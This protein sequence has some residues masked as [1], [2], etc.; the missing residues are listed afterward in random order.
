MSGRAS[1]FPI[2][3]SIT[4]DELESDLH[5]AFARLRDS[6]PVSWVGALDAWLVTSRDAA[7]TMMR[8][9]D[10]FTV[11]DPRFSTAQV[12]G[13]SMLSLDGAEHARHRDPFADAFRLP[14]VR[15][16]FTHAV[17]SLADE[18]IETMR[19]DGRGELRRQLAGPLAVRVMALALQLTDGDPATLLGWYDQI[20]ESVTAISNG[21]PD[22]GSA[23]HAVAQLTASVRTTVQ[24]G[25]GVLA[26]ATTSL[27]T[28]EI[29]S[30][31]GVMLFGGIETSEGMTA[32]AFA[33]LLAQPDLWGVVS[34]DPSLI[35]NAIEESLRLEPSVVRV[36][37]FATRDITFGDASI[38]RGDFV[39]ISLAAAN[40]D[41]AVFDEPDRFDPARAN[42]KQHVTF[43]HGPHACPGMHLA[44]LETHAA[45][46]AAVDG[47]PGLRLDPEA[48][49]PRPT[50]TVF[51]KPDRL[52]V[53]WGQHA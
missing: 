33:H 28:D 2:G 49:P 53:V 23:D 43:V 5:G 29:V 36:D 51:R 41:P 4:E 46:A 45:I 40:R 39:I 42:A 44:R 35:A 20:V 10:A 13:P 17:R 38:D 8:D 22:T 50:G 25:T 34:A 47:W 1:S 16:S 52:D 32:N 18:I 30:N 31:T 3:A 12:L 11:D 15:A 19:Q 14:E 21:R 9:A 37:R 27:S 48:T 24:R 7:V 26:A 6:E